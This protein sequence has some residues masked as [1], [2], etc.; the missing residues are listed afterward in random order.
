MNDIDNC[1]LG[2]RKKKR[3]F[4]PCLTLVFMLIA[5]FLFLAICK[6]TQGFIIIRVAVRKRRVACSRPL[7]FDCGC[8]CYHSTLY[9]YTVG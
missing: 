9:I 6:R 3:F 1:S 2:A 7:K 5:R 4:I 8:Y